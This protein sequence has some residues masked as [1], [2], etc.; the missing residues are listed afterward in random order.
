MKVKAS[1]GAARQQIMKRDRGIC[2][3]CNLDC[4]TLVKKLQ[5]IEKTHE[6]DPESMA[7]WRE[8]REQ[9]LCRKEY[10][11]FSSRLSKAMKDGL[12]EKALSGKAWQADHIIP[13]FEGGGQCTITNL[14]TLCTACHRDVTAEQASKRKRERASFKKKKDT[15]KQSSK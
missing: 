8:Q 7:S 5:S 2:A 14:R 13:V 12:V 15:K 3:M 9:L 1:S 6:S 11:H 4:L 10:Q